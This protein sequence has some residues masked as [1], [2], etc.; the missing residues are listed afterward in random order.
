MS[1]KRIYRSA[2]SELIEHKKTSIISMILII[3]FGVIQFFINSA[4]YDAYYGENFYINYGFFGIL[5]FL[6]FLVCR[7]MFKDMYENTAADVQMSLPLSAK[8]RYCS[9]L[10]TIG[11][12]FWFPLIIISVFSN[13]VSYIYIRFCYLERTRAVFEDYYYRYRLCS[14]DCAPV[15]SDFL[16]YELVLIAVSLFVIAVTVFAVSCIGSKS[17]SLYI[18]ILL[19]AVF[20]LFPVLFFEFITSKFLIFDAD[21]SN[22]SLLKWIPGF[23][24]MFFEFEE[25][26]FSDVFIN[27]LLSVVVLIL[28]LAA[29]EKRD[30]KSVGKPVVNKIFYEFLMFLSSVIIFIIAYI[31]DSGYSFITINIIGIIGMIIL[32]ILGSRKE[33]HPVLL[34]KWIGL[35]V[36]YFI[37]FVIL[38]FAICKTNMFGFAAKCFKDNYSENVN[39]CDIITYYDTN[40]KNFEY[41]YGYYRPSYRN[42]YES[43]YNNYVDDYYLENFE[44][45]YPDVEHQI[46][47]MNN[48]SQKTDKLAKLFSKYNGICINK[49]GFFATKMFFADEPIEPGICSVDF[50]FSYNDRDYCNNGGIR[51]KSFVLDHDDYENLNAELLS[52][53]N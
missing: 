24:I 11:F 23:P 52:I 41:D 16:K 45:L 37:G 15:V 12:V 51:F 22:I 4:T 29:F 36:L 13:I 50:F 42:Y 6:L 30:V 49:S 1:L 53:S 18:P 32:R 5:M 47:D 44:D 48:I 19:I 17:E 34:V 2:R 38:M 25:V 35:Y 10:L 26:T 7:N 8:E 3:V 46:I 20:S 39:N 14:G 9:H 31:S 43:K 33:F 40:K 27:I 21:L 28:G